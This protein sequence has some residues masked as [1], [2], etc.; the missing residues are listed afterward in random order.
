MICKYFLI[1][2]MS[3]FWTLIMKCHSLVTLCVWMCRGPLL[4]LE[5]AASSPFFC[6]AYFCRETVLSRPSRSPLYGR[7]SVGILRF[8][9]RACCKNHNTSTPKVVRE[10]PLSYQLWSTSQLKIQTSIWVEYPAFSFSLSLPIW[11]H[12]WDPEE[13]VPLPIWSQWSDL[14]YPLIG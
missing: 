2:S 9:S 3:V 13:T 5:A 14:C 1:T 4:N 7:Y 12:C 8:Y 11:P 6:L 10:H